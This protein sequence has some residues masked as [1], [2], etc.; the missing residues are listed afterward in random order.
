[1]SWAE[2]G[3]GWAGKRTAVVCTRDGVKLLLPGGVPQHEAHLLRQRLHVLQLLQE[4]HADGLLVLVCEDAPVEGRACPRTQQRRGQQ[5]AGV[6]S[7][8]GMGMERGGERVRIRAGKGA[9]LQKR[10]IM[11]VFPTPPLPTTSTFTS[12]CQAQADG[13]QKGVNRQ[14]R[15]HWAGVILADRGTGRGRGQE[16]VWGGTPR[17]LPPSSCRPSRAA[18]TGAC[19]FEASR[20]AGAVRPQSGRLASRRWKDLETGH[21]V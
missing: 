3:G 20:S 12:L 5:V 17:S 15:K 21:G 8:A 4:V 6:H 18:P 16:W 9:H 7:Q 1:M 19:G 2:W 13:D 10:L 11:E 14:I